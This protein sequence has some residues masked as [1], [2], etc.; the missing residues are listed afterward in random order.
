MWS[1][2]PKISCTTTTPPRGLPLGSARYASSS[3]PSAAF[4]RIIFPT[5]VLLLVRSESR[6][7]ARSRAHDASRKRATRCETSGSELLLRSLRL[8]PAREPAEVLRDRVLVALGDLRGRL[9]AHRRVL[10]VVVVRRELELEL[11]GQVHEPLELLLEKIR[12]AAD[13][14]PG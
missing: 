2:T 11:I 8:R 13:V 1:V 12:I 6:R 4:N 5:V 3:W 9:R 14:E 7:R 10:A